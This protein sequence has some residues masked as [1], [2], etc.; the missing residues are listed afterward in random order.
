MKKFLPFFIFAVCSV[1]LKAQAP[2]TYSSTPDS[3]GQTPRSGSTGTF[4]IAYS[5]GVYTNSSYYSICC[6]NS[7][8]SILRL[9]RFNINVPPT[10]SITGVTTSYSTTAGNGGPANYKI[11]SICLTNNFIKVGNYKRDSINGAGGTFTNGGV[12]DTWG[13]GLTPSIVNSPHFGFQIY[14][15]TY[16]INTTV[17]GAFKLTVHY[18]MPNGIKESEKALLNPLFY[19]E[20]KNLF[21]NSSETKIKI[22]VFSLTGEKVA[23]CMIE[24]EGS[25]NLA[26]LAPGIY[27]YKYSTEVQSG[28]SK[29]IVD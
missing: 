6:N 23:E 13:A 5:G 15:D 14:L 21:I 17:L 3:A 29:F 2:Q 16:G 25:L 11:D 27:I 19:Y 22:S 7:K 28:S 20:N 12:A 9:Y 26:H 8:S 24:K 1:I 4:Q 18:T 10:A